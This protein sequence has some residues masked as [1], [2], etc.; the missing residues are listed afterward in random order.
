[1]EDEPKCHHYHHFAAVDDADSDREN[2][3]I[4]EVTHVER[5]GAPTRA[6]SASDEAAFEDGNAPAAAAVDVAFDVN[7]AAEVQV[8]VQRKAEDDDA[9]WPS[10]PV[11]M[12]AESEH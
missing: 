10:P 4:A 5:A 12:L 1:M 7:G 3:S 2:T 9:F 6:A 11:G 8:V